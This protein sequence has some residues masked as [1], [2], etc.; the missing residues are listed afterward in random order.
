MFFIGYYEILPPQQ[1]IKTVFVTARIPNAL[2]YRTW[3]TE[4]WQ[5]G[6]IKISFYETAFTYPTNSSSNQ[7]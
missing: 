6:K 4:S 3:V 5:K 7:L 2:L 1:K